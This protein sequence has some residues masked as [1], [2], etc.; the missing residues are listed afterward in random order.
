MIRRYGFPIALIA[1]TILAA[2]LRLPALGNRPFHG[3]EAVH[4]FKFR[5]VWEHG[6]YRYDPNEYH[7]PTLYYA[8]LPIV[9]LK[10]RHSFA[11]TQ[12]S[13]YRLATAL[14]GAAIIPLLW[15]FRDALGRRA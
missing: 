7:G 8:A 14:A 5:E 2:A 6:V 10:H 4:A 13:D 9:A 11:E 1:I 12:E 15:L 3:D